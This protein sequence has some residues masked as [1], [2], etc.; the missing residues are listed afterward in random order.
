MARPTKNGEDMRTE[1][2]RVRVTPNEKKQVWNDASEAGL[3]PTDF[4][5]GHILKAD[6]VRKLPTPERAALLK[7]LAENNKIGS[8]IN[9][10][11]YEMHAKH[12][13]DNEKPDIQRRI[14]QAMAEYS[15][16]CK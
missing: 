5:R 15:G 14:D 7:L 16:L 6:P 9:Q 12:F 10:I 11:A 4:M 13:A 8:N 1:L 3:T 2:L